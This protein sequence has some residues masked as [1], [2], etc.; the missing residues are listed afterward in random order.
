MLFQSL[1]YLTFLIVVLAIYWSLPRRGQ[2]VL[3]VAASYIFYGWEHPWYLLPLWTSTLVD[4]GCA[5]GM[6][7]FPLRRRL[8]LLTSVVASIALLGTFKYAGFTVENVNVALRTLGRE[9]IHSVMRLVLP[10]GLSFYTFQSL[11]YIVDVYRGRVR[12]ERNL[13]DYALYVSFFPQLIAGPIERAWHMLPQYRSG[14]IF[15]SLGW[16]AGLS[17]MLWGFFKKLVVAD[18]VAV[19]ANKVFS[20]SD[21][22]FPVLWAGVLAFCVQIYADFS[23]YT[24]IARGTARLLGIDLM[25]NFNHPYLATSPADFWRRWHISFSTWL[26]DFIYIPLGGSRCGA[27]RASFNLMATFAISGLWHGASWNYVLWGIYWGLL[28]LMQRF[29][30]WL[31]VTQSFPWF[32]KVAVTFTITNIGWLLFRERN[33]SQIIYDLSLSP[34]VP[35]FDQWQIGSYLVALVALYAS[36]LIIHMIATVFVLPRLQPRFAWS[37]TGNFAWQSATA[38]LLF[39]GIIVARSVVTSDFIYFQF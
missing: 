30:R 37:E 2:N 13:V 1:T 16:R 29:L 14:R 26:R 5:L 28:I 25:R 15:D 34:F 10:A 20:L 39:F 4:Y 23:G 32:L 33:L 12:A 3:L 27:A 6:E 9:P 24:D 11:A 7:R 19:V 8:F 17:L 38:I 35:G 31:G 36:P 22:T 18:N 21:P